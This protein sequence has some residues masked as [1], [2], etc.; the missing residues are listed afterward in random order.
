MRA[1]TKQRPRKRGKRDAS[2]R[3]RAEVLFHPERLRI[4]QTLSNAKGLT[5][6]DIAERLPDLA[7]ATLYR[8]LK[9]LT[10]AGIVIVA[11]ERQ[12]RGVK[13]RT[14]AVTQETAVISPAE[15]AA[16]TEEERF[17]FFS[18]FVAALL[19]QYARLL[20]HR[21][22]SDLTSVS[23]RQYPLYLTDT[24]MA[25][26]R[27]ELRA[28][29]TRHLENGPSAARTRRLFTTVLMPDASPSRSSGAAAPVE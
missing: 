3:Q 25:A 19:D 13:E 21:M 27:D 7:P 22:G 12:V 11:A 29:L 4:V 5:T 6:R 1:R 8:H 16:F 23:Y 18:R 20:A 15:M 14:Y 2:R 17:G 9:R 28:L 24:E 26:F 10:E